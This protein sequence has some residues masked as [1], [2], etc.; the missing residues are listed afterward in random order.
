MPQGI[1]TWMCQQ[2]FIMR[3]EEK[4]IIFPYPVVVI[5]SFVFICF[6]KNENT[7]LNAAH[8]A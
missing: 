7:K 2:L 1:D 6:V 8:S 3:A 5:P 4:E